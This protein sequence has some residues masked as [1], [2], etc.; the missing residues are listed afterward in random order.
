MGKAGKWGGHRS[1]HSQGDAYYWQDY[2]GYAADPRSW[3]PPRK[4]KDKAP[5]FPKYD[6]MTIV[7]ASKAGMPNGP[8]SGSSGASGGDFVKIVQKLTNNL[9]R[10]EQRIRKN[11]EE[12]GLVDGQWASFQ[13]G[14]KESF[15]RERARYKEC[16]DRLLHEEGEAARCQE[17]AVEELYRRPDHDGGDRRR[18]VRPPRWCNGQLGVQANGCAED[19]GS[20]RAPQGDAREGQDATTAAHTADGDV[21]PCDPWATTRSS[22]SHGQA[23]G[24]GGANWVPVRHFAHDAEPVAIDPPEI[25]VGLTKS[26]GEGKGAQSKGGAAAGPLPVRKARG[27][28]RDDA[29][30]KGCRAGAGRRRGGDHRQPSCGGRPPSGDRDR[31]SLGRPPGPSKHHEYYDVVPE[32]EP[33]MDGLDI[34]ISTEYDKENLEDIVDGGPPLITR[35]FRLV[36]ASYSFGG[37]PGLSRRLFRCVL[38]NHEDDWLRPLAHRPAG[39]VRAMRPLA[40]AAAQA[41]PQRAARRLWDMFDV[42]EAAAE[43]VEEFLRDIVLR[44]GSV[45]GALGAPL[46]FVLATVQ[47][48][49]LMMH[50][51]WQRPFAQRRGTRHATTHWAAI[52]LPFAACI[53]QAR[54]VTPE[55]PNLQWWPTTRPP[56]P[57]DIELWCSGQL[58]V[59]EQ[60]A[61]AL[62]RAIA[63]RPLHSG[64]IWPDGI[65]ANGPANY[66]ASPVPTPVD[67]EADFDTATLLE[68]DEEEA[69]THILSDCYR[70]AMSQSPL[71]SD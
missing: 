16:S 54:A 37:A 62:Q 4:N 10:A 32:Y 70:L 55:A 22:P 11:K 64:G 39:Q 9:R 41:R 6:T 5:L 30:G 19:D 15:M 43:Y 52:L 13:K 47:V 7:E 23:R 56:P 60:T 57:T 26:A 63:G 3:Q 68:D 69:T 12:R 24:G 8:A 51:R 28:P 21:A 66:Q 46:C 29:C 61:L 34:D 50:M 20:A 31:L 65:H 27:Q 38:P 53:G 18:S 33:A 25:A 44:I 45:G 14:L 59:A 58:T 17:S 49:T 35:R 36:L 40:D 48:L 67:A 1:D 42:Y 2:S 71:T